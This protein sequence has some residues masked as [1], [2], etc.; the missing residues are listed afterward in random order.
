[1]KKMMYKISALLGM[2]FFS[3][4]PLFV[5][6]YAI[7]L[8]GHVSECNR[9]VETY[10]QAAKDGNKNLNDYIEKFVTSSDSDFEREGSLIKA[11]VTRAEFLQNAS[12][13]LRE[14]TPVLRPF[15][16]VRYADEKVAQDA[17]KSFAL[18]FSFTVEGIAWC[19][20]GAIF[21]IISCASLRNFFGIK[22]K[23]QSQ[24]KENE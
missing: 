2:L 12:L 15:A 10:R 13:S 24:K 8:E 16:F 5:D 22:A 18:G 9:L 14:T 1:M 23:E 20:F 6:Q 4:I 21:G 19:A 3:Q 7:R 11:V 17:W